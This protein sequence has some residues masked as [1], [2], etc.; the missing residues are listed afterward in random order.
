MVE[1]L[2]GL[3]EEPKI[4]SINEVKLGNIKINAKILSGEQLP[5]FLTEMKNINDIER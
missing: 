5:E 4:D 1:E 3:V 2:K